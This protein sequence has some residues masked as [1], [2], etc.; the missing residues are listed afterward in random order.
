MIDVDKVVQQLHSH[1]LETW[2][3]QLPQQIGRALNAHGDLGRWQ[4][5]LDSLPE[6]SSREVL[7][8][9]GRISIGSQEEIPE[10]L[11]QELYRTLRALQPWR[12]GPFSVFGIDIDTEWRSDWKWQRLRPHI[13]PLAGRRV[14][15]VGC[16]NGYHCW[17]M[18]G[19]GASLVIGIDPNLLF[20]AQFSA[21]RRLIAEPPPAYLLPV[22]IEQLPRGLRA[23]DTV[24]S[25]G[26]LYHRSSPIDHLLE[27]K[28]CLKPGGELVLETLVVEGGESTV[29]VPRGR[30]AKMRNVWFIPSPPALVN[31]LQR[32]GYRDVK[33]VDVAP[34]TT[35]EQHSTDWM[36]FES[37][38]NFLDPADASRTIEGYHAPVRAVVLASA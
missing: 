24:F 7:L 29:L 20:L 18:A 21:L 35:R 22:G 10:K 36:A 11:Q 3:R 37:L 30:Y 14:L 15:D 8:D 28:G 23:F 2:A 17:R 12:K 19:E 4:H 16:G 33:V 38:P 13:R 1:G 34:T 27:L 9:T 5:L 6:L 26:V 31:W 25:M 32:C